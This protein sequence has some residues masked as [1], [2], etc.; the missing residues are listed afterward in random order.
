M[1]VS[2]PLSLSLSLSHTPTYKHILTILSLGG[3]IYIA[4]MPSL[5][6]GGCQAVE[7]AYVLTNILKDVKRRSELPGALQSYY[8]QRIVRATAIQ[9]LSRISNHL[10]MHYYNTPA[11]IQFYPFRIEVPNGLVSIVTSMCKPII[12]TLVYFQFRFVTA[13]ITLQFN[14]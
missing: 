10:L 14:P 5:G 6:Q 2:Y 7:D 9:Y 1:I 4:M 13:C 12:S 3:D 8:Q 11:S